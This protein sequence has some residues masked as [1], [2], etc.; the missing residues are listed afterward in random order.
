V[1]V[2]FGGARLWVNEAIVPVI[3]STADRYATSQNARTQLLRV[4]MGS[5]DT[6]GGN[7]YDEF[8]HVIHA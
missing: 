4:S 1:C 6:H 3:A 8:A 7:F 2:V 5:C